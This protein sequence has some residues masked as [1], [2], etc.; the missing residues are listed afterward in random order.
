MGSKQLSVVIATYNDESCLYLTVMSV[1]QQLVQTSLEWEIIIVADGG[2]PT[3]WEALNQPWLMSHPIRCLR[4]GG[5]NRIGSPQGTRDCGIRAAKF[6]NVLCIESHVVVSDIE[7]FLAC[8]VSDPSNPA[9]SFPIRIAEGTEMYNIYG[10][11]TDWDGNLWFKRL[12]YQ[13]PQRGNYPIAQFGH[14]CFMIDRDWYNHSGGY[15][16]LL[17]GWGGEEPFLCLKAWMLGRRCMMFPTIWHAHYLTPGAHGDSLGSDRMA[18]NFR[19]VRFVMNGDMFP[20][21]HDARFQEE[22]KKI[23]DGPF[24]GNLSELRTYFAQEKVVN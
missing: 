19:I 10:S 1:L 3:K 4:F 15:T 8:H 9:I 20:G 14:S 12:L 16:N 23:V 13:Q 18:H 2:T 24:H 6:R 17:N 11:T 21:C 7:E 22:R 5:G